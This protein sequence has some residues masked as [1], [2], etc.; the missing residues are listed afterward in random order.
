MSRVWS[1]QIR[2]T[3]DQ[4][5]RIRNFSKLKGFGS[6]SSYLRHVALEQDLLFQQKLCEIHSFLLGK[7]NSPPKPPRAALAPL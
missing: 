4:Y 7:G 1:I 5:E 6:M 2:L 3:R